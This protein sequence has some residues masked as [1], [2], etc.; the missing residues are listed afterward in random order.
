MTPLM[1]RISFALALVLPWSPATTLAWMVQPELGYGLG[2]AMTPAG[3]VLTCGHAR[4]ADGYDFSIRLH[5]ASDGTDVWHYRADGTGGA[6]GAVTLDGAG[7]VIAA[8]TTASDA[9]A[10]VRVVKLTPDGVPIW[11]TMIDSATHADDRFQAMAVGPG[12]DVA[13][14]GTVFITHG[15]GRPPSLFHTLRRPPT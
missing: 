3:D 14:G 13:G 1:K 4:G 10:D 15:I 6:A 2:I 7:D 11:T 9:T 5:R 8:G 12:G